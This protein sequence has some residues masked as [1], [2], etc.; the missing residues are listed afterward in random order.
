MSETEQ[1]GIPIEEPE[2][3]PE[4]EGE[5]KE[6]QPLPPIVKLLILVVG[7]IILAAGAF[8]LTQ[9]VILPRI[10]KSSV[11]EKMT[12]VKEKLKKP[13]KKREKKGPVIEHTIQSVTVNV[14]GPRG[15]QFATFDLV[16]MTPEKT[17]GELVSKENQI[18]GALIT[19][20]IGRTVRELSTREFYLSAGDSLRDIINSTIEGGAVDTVFFTQFLIQ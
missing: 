3:S 18:R 8:F 1:R 13:K 4:E 15:L 12:E 16:V 6:S 5:V 20:F 2:E 14:V 11:G 17:R 19:Y 7:V 10:T 9:K